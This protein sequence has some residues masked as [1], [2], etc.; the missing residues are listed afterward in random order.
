MPK[1][2]WNYDS[3][4]T[5]VINNESPGVLPGQS[6][7]FSDEELAIGFTGTWGDKDPRRGLAEERAWKKKRDAVPA[8]GDAES[9]P[10]K[11]PAE[12]GL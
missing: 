10:P 7:V 11:A 12:P 4:Q 9:E 8:T 6:R 3:C 1:T 5:A 2:L